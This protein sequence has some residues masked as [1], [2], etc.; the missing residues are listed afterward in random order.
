MIKNIIKVIAIQFSAAADETSV[1]RKTRQGVQ[2][3]DTGQAISAH[4]AVST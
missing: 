3:H 2:V 4:C 1:F